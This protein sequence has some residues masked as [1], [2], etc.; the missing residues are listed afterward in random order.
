MSSAFPFNRIAMPIIWTTF[1]ANMQ[2]L[3][4]QKLT[5]GETVFYNP[6]AALPAP[7]PL[8]SL[9]TRLTDQDD[10]TVEVTLKLNAEA[11]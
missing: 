3:R 9:T 7:H 2:M 11:R 5:M 6:T 8:Q 1:S 4:A 10:Y